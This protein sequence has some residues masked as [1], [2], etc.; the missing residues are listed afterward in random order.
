MEVFLGLTL[1]EFSVH[2]CREDAAEDLCCVEV[3]HIPEHRIE[4]SDVVRDEESIL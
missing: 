3:S 2:S 4:G 1:A